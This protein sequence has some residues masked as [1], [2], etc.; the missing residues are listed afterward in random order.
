MKIDA[1]RARLTL[2]LI[3]AIP[4]LIDLGKRGAAAGRA[5]VAAIRRK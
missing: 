4:A 5:I 3:V 1:R 2:K